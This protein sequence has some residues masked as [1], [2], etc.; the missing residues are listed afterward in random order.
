MDRLGTGIRG[1]GLGPL[2]GGT[3]GPPGT[4]MR[5]PTGLRQP[6]GTA[7]GARMGTAM[8]PG[9]RA[10]LGPLNTNIQ[11]AERPVTQQGMMGMK[12]ISQGPGR[13][14]QDRSYYMGEL[15][16]RCDELQAEINKM[17]GEAE[18]YNKDNETYTRFEKK[19]NTLI[20]EVRTLQGDLADLNLIADKSRNNTDPQ[21]IDNNFQYL[22]Q[23]VQT[24]QLRAL[25]QQLGSRAPKLFWRPICLCPRGAVGWSNR[26][27]SSDPLA[28]SHARAADQSADPSAPHA[29]LFARATPPFWNA[30]QRGV[31]RAHVAAH[32]ERSG[33]GTKK[34]MF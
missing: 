18:Q 5:P 8:R 7:M 28:R 12:P 25:S 31:D 29:C 6:M 21:D 11:V 30:A 10:G 4:A 20:G 3:M 2:G 9:S 27:K 24:R 16:K 14:I 19:Y 22:K 17:S 13:Q 23:V 15:R 33:C 32:C 26:P 1:G 34:C